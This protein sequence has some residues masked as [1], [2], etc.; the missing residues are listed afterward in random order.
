MELN[1]D[2]LKQIFT[3]EQIANSTY[4]T[5]RGNIHIRLIN[6]KPTLAT[7]EALYPSV[8]KTRKSLTQ[9][10][11]VIGKRK[12]M[13]TDGEYTGNQKID[14]NLSYVST[15]PIDIPTLPEDLMDTLKDTPN[16]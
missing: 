4:I 9:Y 8:H 13:S 11:N 14:L 7:V 6:N 1:I 12:D 15:L 3:D 5:P 10:T 16:G 2:T